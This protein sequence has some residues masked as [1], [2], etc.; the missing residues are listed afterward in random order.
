[1]AVEEASACRWGQLQQQQERQ[2]QQQGAAG[3]AGAAAGAAAAAAVA[4]ATAAVFAFATAVKA[5][6]RYR[7][8]FYIVELSQ[9]QTKSVIRFSDRISSLTRCRYKII[10]DPISR[11]EMPVYRARSP[12]H[13][14]S[15][16]H[17]PW[18]LCPSGYWSCRREI[19]PTTYR[20]DRELNLFFQLSQLPADPNALRKH[21]CS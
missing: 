15:L 21:H 9:N 2:Q 6:C 14:E 16:D 20:F 12:C 11:V 13:W 10:Y 4:G 1:M 5:G 17:I 3:A 7:T 8:K 19:Q 18:Q